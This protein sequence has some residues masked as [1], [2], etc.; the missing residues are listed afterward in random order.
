MA[1]APYIET[2]CTITHEGKTFESGGAV[3]TDDYAI[4]YVGKPLGDGMGIDRFGPTSRRAL[5]DWH[6]NQIGTC[7]ISQSWRVFSYMG[8]HMCQIYATIDG[9]TYTG[10]GFGE[11]MIWKGKRVARQ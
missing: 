5:N 3:V 6:G 1:R 8:S 7:Y 10:R 11:G 9:V 4:G 2:D